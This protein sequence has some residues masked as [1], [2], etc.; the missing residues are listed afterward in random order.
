MALILWTVI[1]ETSDLK[2]KIIHEQ[3]SNNINIFM[4]TTI[5]YD[6]LMTTLKGPMN[7]RMVLKFFTP[8]VCVYV[9]E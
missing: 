9:V 4:K 8:K 1:L 6:I 5:S 7:D 2:E 3:N